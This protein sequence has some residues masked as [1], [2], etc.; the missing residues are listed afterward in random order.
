MLI[1]SKAPTGHWLSL[2]GGLATVLLALDSGYAQ[3]AELLTVRL[4]SGRVFSGEVDPSTSSELL[5]LRSGRGGTTVRRP[6]EWP[7]I[8]AAWHQSRQVALSDLPR[9]A[10]SLKNELEAPDKAAANTNL[11]DASYAAAALIGPDNPGPPPLTLPRI[12]SVAFDAQIANW[13]ADVEMD[14]L[15]VLI[16]P[17]DN[18]GQITPA[19][20]TVEIE[21]FAP[22]LRVFHHA[23]LSGGD[24]LERVERWTRAIRSDEFG[25]SGFRLRLP[26]GAVHP[27]FDNDWLAYGLVH[28]RMTAPGHGVFDDSRDGIRIRPWA[29]LRDQ[30]ELNTGRR[31]VPTEAVGRHN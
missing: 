17:L 24:T 12:M 23:P 13:D 9:L 3:G 2:L 6:I 31:F 29:P 28:V 8:E 10:E 16:Q 20:G 30:L 27:E 18:D 25:H 7:R 11:L 22:Q 5:V 19:G 4:A 21:L 15:V 1:E 14:G 26:F